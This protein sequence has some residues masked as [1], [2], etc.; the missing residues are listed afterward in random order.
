LG[1]CTLDSEYRDDFEK[2]HPSTLLVLLVSQ[3]C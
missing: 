2:P 1:R 3:G